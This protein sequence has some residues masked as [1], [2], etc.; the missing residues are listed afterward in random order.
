MSSQQKKENQT[1]FQKSL[2][3]TVVLPELQTCPPHC[4]TR[5]T[6]SIP[7]AYL[8]SPRHLSSAKSDTE[9]HY[10]FALE[11]EKGKGF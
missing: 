8:H 3:P 1:N 9:I 6:R 7:P 11:K 10:S 4:G 5:G 2:T